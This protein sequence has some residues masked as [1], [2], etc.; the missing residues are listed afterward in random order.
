MCGHRLSDCRPAAVTTGALVQSIPKDFRQQK[1]ELP[2]S[3][4]HPALLI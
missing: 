2:Y 4:H 3:A 1:P